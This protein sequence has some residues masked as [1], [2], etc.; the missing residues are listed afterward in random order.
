MDQASLAKKILAEKK[1]RYA[2]KEE[3]FRAKDA[4]D[5]V[6]DGVVYNEDGTVTLQV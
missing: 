4:L 3:F 1:V 5:F 2:S 6:G